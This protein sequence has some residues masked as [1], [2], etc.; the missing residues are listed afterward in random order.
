MKTRLNRGYYWFLI[1]GFILFLIF[2]M[3]PFV[4]NIYLS[5]TRWSGVGIPNSSV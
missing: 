4:A 1:P 3:L 5:F 2:V